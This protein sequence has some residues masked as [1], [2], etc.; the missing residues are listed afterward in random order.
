[1][2]II[3]LRRKRRNPA[4]KQKRHVFTKPK[5]GREKTWRVASAVK[6]SVEKTE[7]RRNDQMEINPIEKQTEMES[8]VGL[9]DEVSE[10]DTSLKDEPSLLEDETGRIAVATYSPDE[11]YYIEMIF[12]QSLKKRRVLR[13]GGIILVLLS[14]IQMT[15]NAPDYERFMLL[16]ALS[17]AGLF[18]FLYAQYAH[19]F[20]GRSAFRKIKKKVGASN[21][22]PRLVHEYYADRIEIRAERSEN[23]RIYP[24]S[25]MTEIRN[26]KTMTLF[27]FGSMYSVAVPRKAFSFGTAQ[28]VVDYIRKNY[29]IKKYS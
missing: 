12:L 20:K 19:V 25:N 4:F 28:K 14:G 1:M 10:T 5:K 24:Y 2:P 7:N 6:A 9:Q 8:T 16:G 22:L 18:F 15:R 21:W 26:T 13:F 11:D 29:S 27:I 23:A 17:I 3:V